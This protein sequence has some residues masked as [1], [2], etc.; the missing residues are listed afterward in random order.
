MSPL[1]SEVKLAVYVASGVAI[2]AAFTVLVV[3]GQAQQ[4]LLDIKFIF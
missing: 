3:S 4:Q 1:N 2:I